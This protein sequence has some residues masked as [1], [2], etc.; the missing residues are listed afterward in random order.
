MEVRPWVGAHRT[1]EMDDSDQHIPVSI[2]FIGGGSL[3]WAAE[4]MA[5]L[6]RDTRLRANVRLFDIDH[7][8]ARRNAEIGARFAGV[9]RG[10]PASYT[11]SAS[12]AEALDG[13]D[14]VV[15]SILPG[16]FDDMAQDIAIPAAFGIPQAVGDTVGPGGFVR[17]LRAI[18]MLA[19]IARAIRDHAPRAH[20]CNLTNPMSVLTGTLHAVFPGIRAWGECHEVTKIRRQVAQIANDRAG[21]AHYGHRDVQVNVL[22]INH[23]TFVNRISLAGRDMMPAYLEFVRAHMQEGWVQTEPG[24]DEEHARYFGTKNLVAFD[25]FRRFGIPAAAGDR[26]LAEFLPVSDYLNAP[27]RWGFALTP[28]AYRVRD[29]E[30]KLQRAEALRTGERAPRASRSDEALVDQIVAL[31]GGEAHVSNVNLPNIG[32]MPD[33]PE[34]SIVETNAVFTQGGVAPVCAGRLPAALGTLVRDHALRQAALLRAV[35]DADSAALFPLFR[36]DPLV[37]PMPEQAAREMFAQM[38]AATSHVLPDDLKGA[39]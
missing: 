33:L 38:L 24:K 2:A 10:A 35:L 13:A 17:A 34:G 3:N 4:L 20:V 15:I 7:A 39:A 32:Q 11:A 12:L 6:A 28:V 16:S 36:S 21:E 8:A 31:M 23:F 30:A 9:S 26:H 5:D 29:R 37:A 1:F 14:V 19:E 27:E 22:G 25:L 18:P